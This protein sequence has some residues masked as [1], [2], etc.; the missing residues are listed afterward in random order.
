MS[1]VIVG[2][3]RRKPVLTHV[4]IVCGM[5]AS[6]NS[7]NRFARP[8]GSATENRSRVSWIGGSRSGLDYLVCPIKRSSDYSV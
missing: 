8:Y 1:F 6:V 5:L 2:V 4:S 7:V 3:L